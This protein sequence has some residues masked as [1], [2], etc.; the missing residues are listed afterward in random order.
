LGGY[1]ALAFAEI[2]PE[3]T[4]NLILINSHPFAD[5]SEKLINREREIEILKKGKKDFLV[6]LNIP[7]NFNPDN[8]LHFKK[9]IEILSRIAINSSLEGLISSLHGMK[10]RKDRASVMNS[11]AL[12]IIWMLGKYDQKIDYYKMISF[13]EKLTHIKLITME[14]SGHMGFIEEEELVYQTICENVI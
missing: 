9:E 4:K 13:T 2:Y 7:E 12:K 10:I 14:R 3:K 6:N 5:N 8:Q 11:R 1:I